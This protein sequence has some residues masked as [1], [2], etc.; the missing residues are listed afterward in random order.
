MCETLEREKSRPVNSAARL[1]VAAVGTIAFREGGIMLRRH[2][3]STST[4][5]ASSKIYV[6]IGRS[7][8]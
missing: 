4:E 7:F 6:L 5:D 1:E 3:I 8:H 2:E